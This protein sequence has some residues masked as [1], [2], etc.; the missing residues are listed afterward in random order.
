[1][2]STRWYDY[3][4][5]VYN[6]LADKLDALPEGFP[7]TKNGVEL[8]I[9][10]KLFS[11]E[12][13]LAACGLSE[14]F[15]TIEETADILNLSPKET[16]VHLRRMVRKRIITWKMQEGKILYRL[17]PFVIGFYEHQ[18]DTIDY[19]LAHLVE[20]YFQEGGTEGLMRFSPALHRVIPTHHSLDREKKETILPYED[21]VKQIE[22]GKTFVAYDC[23][24]RKQQDLIEKRD[25]DFPIDVCMA[26]IDREIPQTPG[27]ISKA[28]AMAL[29]DRCE[30]VGL[31]HTV[32]NVVSGVDYICNCCGCCC[33][34]LR[35]IAE[36]GID[37]SV[38]KSNYQAVVFDERCIGCG[39]CTE[40]C[41]VD[42][43]SVGE[44][45]VIKPEK[46]IGCG[47]CVT[48]CPEEA[49]RMVLKP[50]KSRVVPPEDK[51]DWDR[52]RLKNRL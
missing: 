40:R 31:V 52:Q 49:I 46:C 41:H 6:K 39:I 35:G 17:E 20:H 51:D 7:R 14:N 34:I 27:V 44:I 4:M 9:L 47:L 26:V 38:A 32:R 8:Q 42:A 37:G 11:E 23:I 3:P 45:A 13:A 25:C 18:T 10:A 24:C 15:Q 36:F 48:K 1:M 30:D 19:E 50:E 12:D 2:R 33:G 28:E 29:I 22:R 43:V 5:D 21:V 16:K